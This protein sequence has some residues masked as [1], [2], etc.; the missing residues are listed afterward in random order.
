MEKTRPELVN[1][2]LELLKEHQHSSGSFPASPNFKEFN[3]CFLRDASYCAYA[4]LLYGE[5]GSCKK[6]LQWCHNTI[7]ACSDNIEAVKRKALG[8]DHIETNEFLAVR[9]E[10]DGS[11]D[12]SDWP[13]FQIDCYGA[14][15]WCL[16][17]YVTMTGDREFLLEVRTSVGL[18]VSYLETVW[19]FACF[20][21]WEE[22]NYRRHTSSLVCVAG[23]LNSV[24]RLYGNRDA[25]QLAE[26]VQYQILK[27]IT[28][29]GI[30]PKFLTGYGI[31]SSNIWLSVPFNVIPRDAPAMA[32]TIEAI[33]SNLKKDGGL[34]RYPEDSY[35][36]GG[37]WPL[38]NSFLAW[39]KIEIGEIEEAEELLVWVEGQADKNGYFPENNYEI[40]LHPEKT[41]KWIEK[42]GI[43]V[44][45]PLLWTQAMYLIA[46]HF[47][48]GKNN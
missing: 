45:T 22:H 41:Q 21:C 7:M 14:W 42:W 5:A 43:R 10:L 24:A 2:S 12:R 17:E 39:H 38:L 35:Y 13:N 47:L 3:Y 8:S 25:K 11:L 33:E 20:D 27:A 32:R 9:F 1:I 40:P 19:T 28:P 15:L 48:D 44:S 26:K 4:L 46:V 36:G 18:T 16:E 37:R 6:F 29:D 23:G 34:Y 30:F 31:D